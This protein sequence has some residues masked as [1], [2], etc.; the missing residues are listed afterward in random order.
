ME[1]LPLNDLSDAQVKCIRGECIDNVKGKIK[2]LSFVPKTI[3]T[4]FGGNDH[5]DRADASVEQLT[6]DYAVLF[7]EV[8]DKFPETNIII[9][10]LPQ[11]FKDDS[12]RNKVNSSIYKWENEKE[13]Q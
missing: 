4:Q 11:C 6:S 5:L 9:S 13:I 12:I 8:K 2:E 3:I 1:D 7:T 10:G